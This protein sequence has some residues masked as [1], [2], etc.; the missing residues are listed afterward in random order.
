MS[1]QDAIKRANP[2]DSYTAVRS[3]VKGYSGSSTIDES[4]VMQAQ[5][6]SSQS[7]SNRPIDKDIHASTSAGESSASL[8]QDDTLFTSNDRLKHKDSNPNGM[9]L[10]YIAETQPRL[11]LMPVQI[12]IEGGQKNWKSITALSYAIEPED[13]QML[14]IIY[15]QHLFKLSLPCQTST[16]RRTE[17]KAEWDIDRWNFRLQMSQNISD[18]DVHYRQEFTPLSA[19][20]LQKMRPSALSCNGCSNSIAKTD[21]L[22][23]Y[24]PLPSQHWEELVD[25]WMCHADQEL[26]EGMIDTQK[27]LDEH[28]DVQR[29]QARVSEDDLIIV[30]S[31]LVHRNTSIDSLV[32]SSS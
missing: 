32:S 28:Q 27:K 1:N 5:Q 23:Q 17:G 22:D 3:P 13:R 15:V 10:H 25:A 26:N 2:V 8:Y 4:S 11:G 12:W 24:L 30:S 21:E 31:L 20:L 16:D 18:D 19:A 9:K 14:T 29:R 7:G 6:G